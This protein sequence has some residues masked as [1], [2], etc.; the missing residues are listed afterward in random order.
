[1]KLG[2]LSK[3]LSYKSEYYLQTG[4]SSSTT[5]K[6]SSAIRVIPEAPGGV[7]VK[8][9]AAA[10]IGNRG[11]LYPIRPELQVF[12]DYI[13]CSKMVDQ[14]QINYAAIFPESFCAKQKC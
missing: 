11:G 1:M 6:S 7:A 14:H 10:T 12:A 8:T 13:N 9:H 2:P 4:F 3:S 5:L